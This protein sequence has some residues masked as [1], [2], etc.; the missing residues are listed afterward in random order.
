MTWHRYRARLSMDVPIGGGE[1]TAPRSRQLGPVAEEA[2]RAV[3]NGPL[4]R[5][6]CTRT[7]CAP[8]GMG[9]SRLLSCLSQSQCVTDQLGMLA[10]LCFLL[11]RRL[12]KKGA[13]AVQVLRDQSSFSSWYFIEHA[14]IG[15]LNV[16]VTIALTSSVL[17]SRGRTPNPHCSVAGR[18]LVDRGSTAGTGRA[19]SQAAAQLLAHLPVRVHGHPAQLLAGNSLASTKGWDV[20]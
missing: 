11:I 9:R 8:V 7:C 19:P 12:P 20:T 10:C 17:A 4:C 15:D 2:V 14:S 16:N 6:S 18:M 13:R 3:Q 5:R 1:G